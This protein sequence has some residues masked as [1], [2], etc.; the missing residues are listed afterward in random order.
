VLVALTVDSDGGRQFEFARALSAAEAKQYQ[1]AHARIGQK[2]LAFELVDLLNGNLMAAE[3]AV[4]AVSTRMPGASREIEVANSRAANRGIINYLTSIRLYLD[5]TNA[6]LQRTYG[7]ASKP[8][9]AFTVATRT[10]YDTS[11]VYPFV[12]KLQNYA[13]HC[14]MPLRVIRMSERIV[15]DLDGGERV[16]FESFV[17]CNRDRLLADYDSWGPHAKVFIN[18]QNNEFELFPVLKQFADLL[19]K[20][21]KAVWAAETREKWPDM[22]FVTGL[23]DEVCDG[24]RRAEVVQVQKSPGVEWLTPHLYTPLF[25]TLHQLGLLREHPTDYGWIVKPGIHLVRDVE[26]VL[27]E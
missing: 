25:G 8:S 18:A 9:Q 4:Q 21:Q 14:A 23:C 6:R 7:A 27:R 22:L 5:H 2:A 17:G 3:A 1:R 16:E 10:S 12:Y 15:P 24:S 13:Q 20:V 11:P 26:L 19:D